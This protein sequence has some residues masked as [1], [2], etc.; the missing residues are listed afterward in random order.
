MEFILNK[1]LLNFIKT[2]TFSGNFS[3]IE[4]NIIWNIIRI[5]NY[6]N[7]DKRQTA[8]LILRMTALKNK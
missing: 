8:A 2:K 3:E 4:S 7:I 1:N 6:F 5:N